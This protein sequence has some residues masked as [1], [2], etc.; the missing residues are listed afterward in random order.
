MY[1]Q[2]QWRLSK[3]PWACLPVQPSF[4]NRVLY[5]GSSLQL[6][7]TNQISLVFHQR[8]SL[9]LFDRSKRDWFKADPQLD[10][11][12]FSFFLFFFI[13]EAYRINF[14]WKSS[15]NNSY[16]SLSGNFSLLCIGESE[17][18]IS[19]FLSS[20]RSKSLS[21]CEYYNISFVTTTIDKVSLWI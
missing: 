18:K 12:S 21:L 19:N 9:S 3:D 17:K 5:I 1:F 2:R 7:I 13:A 8:V 11:S 6:F 20:N 16:R 15:V 10:F 14:H 4:M